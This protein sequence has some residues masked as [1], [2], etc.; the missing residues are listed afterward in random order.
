MTSRRPPARG[1][2]AI[3]G[4]AFHDLMAEVG[5]ARD[6]AWHRDYNL[7][8]PLGGMRA[9]IHG[10][11]SRYYA[12]FCRFDDPARAARALGTSVNPHSGKWNHHYDDDMDPRECVAEF[13]TRLRPVLAL[14]SDH[15]TTGS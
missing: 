12:V 7:A 13:A 1:K 9:S 10:P 6:P 2:V 15:D 3:F 8:T 4:R 14:P 11:D 5:A